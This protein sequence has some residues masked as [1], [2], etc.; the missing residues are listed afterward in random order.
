MPRYFFTIR[1]PGSEFEDDPGGMILPN[2]AAALSHAAHAI[3]ELQKRE[4]YDDPRL[5]MIV[6]NETRQP[7]LS[8]PFLPGCA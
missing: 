2:D 6:K 7:L 5:M 3:R 8:L 1:R 4:G